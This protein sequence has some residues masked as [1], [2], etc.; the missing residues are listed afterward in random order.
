MR[1][2]WVLASLLLL[3]SLSADAAKVDPTKYGWFTDYAQ[4]KAEAKRTGKPMLL[5]F[6]CEP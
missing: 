6:R 4:A 1:F 2:T 5:V 3:T